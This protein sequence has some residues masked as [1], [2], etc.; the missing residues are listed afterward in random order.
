MSEKRAYFF[1]SHFWRKKCEWQY[2][3]AAIVL[4]SGL[5]LSCYAYYYLQH[6][7]ATH[8]YVEFGQASQ[9]RIIALKKVLEIDSLVI[10]AVG[11]FYNGSNY[12]ERDEFS[13]F[14]SPLLQNNSSVMF[15]L[16]VPRVNNQ[17]ISEYVNEAESD[18]LP[19]YK[20]TPAKNNDL[21]ETERSED[22]YP[23]LYAEAKESVAN[24]LGLDLALIPACWKTMRQA[25]D[26]GNLI[27]SPDIIPEIA[28]KGS[29]VYLFLPIYHKDKKIS[30]H[31]TVEDRR[32]GLQGFIVT[33]LLFDGI[34]EES[35]KTM[36][37]AGIDMYVFDGVKPGE[38]KLVY[39]HISRTW[40]Q[41][42][43]GSQANPTINDSAKNVSYSV[44]YGGR[45]WQVVCVPSAK[46]IS[47]RHT[48]QPW[49]TSFIC[50]LFTFILTAYLLT[51][52]VRNKKKALHTKQLAD[53]NHRLRDEIL[54]R[55]YA[56][57]VS[58]RENAK[59]SAMISAMEEGVVFADVNNIVVEI[60]SYLCQFLEVSREEVLGKRLEELHHGEALEHLVKRINQF[61]EEVATKPFVLQRP[62][63]DKEVILRMQ[64]IYRDGVYDG[65]LFNV[66]DVSELVQARQQ[67]EVANQAKSNFLANMSHEI[68]TPMTAILGYLDL[69]MDPKIE[70]SNRN[71]YLMTVRRNSEN[72]LHLIND[73]LDLSKIEAGKLTINKQRCSIVA[74]LA[75]IASM[76]RPRADLRGNSLTIE[77]MSEMPET[78]E[79]DGIRLRQAVVN[80]VGNAIKF[81]D[82]GR[83][84]VKVYYLSHWKD[85]QS[86]VKIEV[87]DT[88][89]GIR[90]E[91]LSHLFE[92]FNQ[93][94]IT[95]SQKYGGTGLGL[96]ISRHLAELLGGELTVKSVFGSGSTF[97]LIIP[98]GS[99]ENVN[100][101]QHPTEIIEDLNTNHQQYCSNDLSGLNILVAEDS[102]DN[103][104]LIKL[105]LTKAGAKVSFA[106]NGL[107]AVKK[108]ESESFDIVLMDM[109]MPE[110]DGFEATQLLRSRGYTRPILAL[111][112]N[113]M[114][115]DKERCMAIGCNEHLSKPIDRSKMIKAIAFFSGKA[116]QNET[117]EF[118]NASDTTEDDSAEKNDAIIS[119]Y[120]DDPD[121]ASLLEGYVD[122]LNSQIE[123]MYTALSNMQF[124]ELQRLAHI[125]KGSGGNYGYPM[126]TLVAK[127]LED[128]AKAK[129][130]ATSRSALEAIVALCRSIQNG[131]HERNVI[132]SNHP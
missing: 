49:L 68:R 79:T 114:T 127:D 6:K 96:V 61:R 64:P 83:V 36:V 17:Q 63:G 113:A 82:N 85:G 99:L 102:T 131:F 104:Q 42:E 12:V 120:V 92:P 112:A 26:T 67:A 124:V 18:G 132:G 84:L 32:N 13:T 16:W 100:M 121:I 21:E 10:N 94:D 47:M 14:V 88:G 37:P 31:S 123:E 73:I 3:V 28:S 41:G 53:I 106:D 75:D 19:N 126:L 23:V 86:A 110:M 34:A 74:M 125:M 55:K 129:D 87:I 25:C 50:M 108:A 103:Q 101:L 46:F 117:N 2:G 105:L 76:M 90:E 4:I 97:T 62:F 111:T 30:S 40:A 52:E 11:S 128:A 43:K 71:N 80:M 7:E 118:L 54:E 29:S 1:A 9:N 38:S 58:S 65:V 35:F 93:G 109:N 51:I 66:I 60:N 89:I 39:K 116:L 15:M 56:E 130:V 115:D 98:T 122:R 69:M 107:I 24:L 91:V 77:Y 22:H 27:A 59:L 20:I 33:A 57:F 81:T 70:S 72:L 48:W 8:V 119:L 45:K 95:T 44:D 78:V 5:L